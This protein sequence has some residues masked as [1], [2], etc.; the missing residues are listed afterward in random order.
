[1]SL[2]TQIEQWSNRHNPRWLVVLRAGLGLCLFVKGI[3]F[4]KHSIILDEIFSGS[5]EQ[6]SWLATVLPYIHL[7]GGALIVAGLF[8]RFWCI[9]HIPILVG[10]IFLVNIRHGFFSGGTDLPFSIIILLL[11]CFFLVEGSGRLSLDEA[12]RNKHVPA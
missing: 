8:T 10:A 11:L 1:M 2:L 7:L 5:L 6:F 12:L 3:Q 4:I 9:V